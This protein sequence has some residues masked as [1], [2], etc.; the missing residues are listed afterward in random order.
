MKDVLLQK[1]KKV[2]QVCNLVDTTLLQIVGFA[3]VCYSLLCYHGYLHCLNHV[4]TS[5][6]IASCSKPELNYMHLT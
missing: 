4:E 3:P 5:D 1:E 2:Q 6:Y